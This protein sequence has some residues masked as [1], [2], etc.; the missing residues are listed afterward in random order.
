MLLWGPGWLVVWQE[1]GW[2]ALGK[3]PEQLTVWRQGSAVR[4]SAVS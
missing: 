1:L 2:L 3:R 4:Q